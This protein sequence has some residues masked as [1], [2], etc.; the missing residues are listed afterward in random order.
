MT[1]LQAIQSDDN[2]IL[3][4]F[5]GTG[6]SSVGRLLAERLGYTFVDTDDVI[7]HRCGRAVHEIF[8]REG[9]EAFRAREAALAR[10]LAAGKRQVIATGGRLML[11]ADNAAVLS[12]HGRV[13]CLWASAEEIM[14]R[15][16]ADTAAVRP[17]L[18]GPDPES[19]IRALYAER[20]EGYARFTPIMTSGQTVSEVVQAVC[21]RLAVAQE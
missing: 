14:A 8:R 21:E 7:A 5:M 1:T 6:K 4:G 20:R 2:I 19:R 10:E 15:V 9:E 13:F 11:D 3:T 12:R 16:A 17:L 18:A